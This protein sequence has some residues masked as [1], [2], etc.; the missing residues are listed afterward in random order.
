[1]ALPASP[2]R[3]RISFVTAPGPHPKST[4]LRRPGQI[5][6]STIQRLT[7]VKNGW[8]V[9]ASNEKRSDSS[10]VR[11]AMRP[12]VLQPMDCERAQVYVE[13]VIHAIAR[14]TL[15]I[16]SG[17]VGGVDFLAV[18][19][20]ADLPTA[21][22][23]AQL[24]HGLAGRVG[25]H[26]RVVVGPVRGHRGGRVTRDAAFHQELAVAPHQEVG[27]AVLRVREVAAADEQTV[28]L[29]V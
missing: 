3:S 22:Y 9:N 14:N 15:G 11:L 7:S 21:H 26:D 16:E 13:I 27:V 1:M 2:S 24:V 29:R 25:L 19:L 23:D 10:T 28:P 17:C 8:R 4:I 6:R 20:E 5:T 12:P 18:H